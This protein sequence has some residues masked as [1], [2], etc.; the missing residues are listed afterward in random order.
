M[1]A[2]IVVVFFLS[3]SHFNKL[4]V[5]YRFK[6]ETSEK[7]YWLYMSRHIFTGSIFKFCLLD[8]VTSCFLAFKDNMFVPK[9]NLNLS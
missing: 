4:V 1:I 2:T 6:F 3:F 5:C 8:K 9:V 7:T